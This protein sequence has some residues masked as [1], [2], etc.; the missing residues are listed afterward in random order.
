[1][2]WAYPTLAAT[3]CQLPIRCSRFVIDISIGEAGY[4]VLD[5][6]HPDS[7][8]LLFAISCASSSA[9]DGKGLRGK[10]TVNMRAYNVSASCNPSA[11]HD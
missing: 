9:T 6:I 2:S 10:S 7:R 4:G 8:R 11:L 5:A 1:M 3:V